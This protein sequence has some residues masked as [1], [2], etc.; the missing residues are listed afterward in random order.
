MI[1]LGVTKT[2]VNVIMHRRCRGGALIDVDQLEKQY[3]SYR[4]FKVPEFA[5]IP[6]NLK[7]LPR[8]KAT[9]LRQFVFYGGVV[10]LKQHLPEDL[11]EH[12]MRLSLPYRIVS[13][14]SFNNSLL[15]AQALFEDFVKDFSHFYPQQGRGYNVHG[16]LH[17]GGG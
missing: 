9:E 1:D 14:D 17:V 8:F 12:F 16:L 7:D 10:L 5:R 4:K 2:I 3:A 13:C 6:R 15:T 11:C